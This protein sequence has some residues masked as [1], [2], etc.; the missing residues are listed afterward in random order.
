MTPSSPHFRSSEPD[1]AP[2][3]NNTTIAGGGTERCGFSYKFNP[4][5]ESNNLTSVEDQR[6]RLNP[7]WINPEVGSPAT[8]ET[9]AS[10][11]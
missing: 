6:N 1:A 11:D 5:R 7:P 2:S 9:L 10:N 8:G 4:M 3:S